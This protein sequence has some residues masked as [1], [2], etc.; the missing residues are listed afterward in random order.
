M[1]LRKI[2]ENQEIDY[3]NVYKWIV[4][5]CR[6][7]DGMKLETFDLK[8]FTVGTNTNDEIYINVKEYFMIKSDAEY[9]PYKF[10]KCADF[11]LYMP[12]LKDCSMFP[13]IL[14]GFDDDIELHGCNSLDFGTFPTFYHRIRL[15]L[16]NFLNITIAEIFKNQTISIDTMIVGKCYA[17]DLHDCDQWDTIKTKY[18]SFDCVRPLKN[19]T[20]ILDI[21]A[22]RLKTFE[23]KRMNRNSYYD[24]K[25]VDMLNRLIRR[26][27]EDRH[28]ASDYIMDMTLALI[29]LG[30]EDMI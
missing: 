19:F 28:N 15:T 21:P 17:V 27:R 25:T 20:H 4:D 8:G 3:E 10:N 12:N 6:D 30:F 11:V 1:K 24:Q 22:S 16:D 2:V 23:L 14:T 13:N 7:V 5:N 26:Y 29:D 18:L 9:L